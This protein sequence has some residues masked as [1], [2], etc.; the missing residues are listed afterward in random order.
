MVASVQ[1]DDRGYPCPRRAA[2]RPRRTG[3]GPVVR[4]WPQPEDPR[5]RSRPFDPS[6]RRPLVDRSYRTHRSAWGRIVGI[7][8]LLVTLGGVSAGGAIWTNAFG[9]GDRFDHLQD[10]IERFLAGPPP[11]RPTVPTVTVTEEPSPS[12]TPEPSPAPSLKPGDSPPPRPSPTPA[13]VRR[14]VDVNLLRN[15]DRYFTTELDNDWCAVAGTQMVLAI[16]GRGDTSESL[17]GEIAG[18]I[19]EWESRADSLN[20]GWG[21][22]AM[23]EAL[24]DYGVPGYEI[25]AYDSRTR[26]MRDAARAIQ[27]TRAPVILLTWRGAHTWVM[28]GFRADADPTLFPDAS[29]TGTYILDPWYPRISSIWGPSDGP[30]VF[31]DLDEMQRN[32]LKWER[33]EGSYP[34]RD[35]LFIAVVPTIPIQ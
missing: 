5:L 1:M 18:R 34:D 26:A 15:P 11:D 8:V 23:V 16:H 31:Q 22:A 13:P 33:P 20:G 3:V 17:Q 21:P 6:F 9:M 2:S 32:Y 7:A 30:G 35:G 12:A 14:P 29:V 28:T 25:R 27:R 19:R 10:R 4:R 24:T